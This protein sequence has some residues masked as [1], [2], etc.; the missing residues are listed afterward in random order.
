M[1][2][3][4]CKEM[5]ATEEER[6]WAY[7]LSMDRAEVDYRNGLLLGMEE[8][9]EEG[10]EEGKKNPCAFKMYWNSFVLVEWFL[11]SRGGRNDLML[12]C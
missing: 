6:A 8:A 2:E 9:G 1:A 12:F 4:A 10:R 3:Q 5:T 7:H 11:N